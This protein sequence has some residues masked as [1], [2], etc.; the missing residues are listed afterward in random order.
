M[1]ELIKNEHPKWLSFTLLATAVLF[2]FFM[3]N[4][5]LKIEKNPI[6]NILY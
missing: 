5:Y 6:T 4:H 3:I 1:H 2:P